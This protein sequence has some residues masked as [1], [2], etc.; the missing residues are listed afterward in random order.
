MLLLKIEIECIVTKIKR[1][2]DLGLMYTKQTVVSFSF[3]NER[4]G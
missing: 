3:C 1:N 2:L 4:G